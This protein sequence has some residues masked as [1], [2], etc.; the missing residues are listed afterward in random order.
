MVLAF[1]GIDFFAKQSITLNNHEKMCSKFLLI[2]IYYCGK[3]V[4]DLKI[5]ENHPENRGKC[6][7]MSC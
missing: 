3:N 4:F 7:V 5:T 1:V 6:V 2:A